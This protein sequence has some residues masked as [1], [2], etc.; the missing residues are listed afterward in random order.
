MKLAGK[1]PLSTRSF[2]TQFV[3][4]FILVL[5]LSLVASIVTYL[6]GIRLYL[7][8]EGRKVQPANYFEQQIPQIEAQIREMGTT[9]LQDHSLLE[10]LV[11]HE[12]LLYQVVDEK[13]VVLY[14]TDRDRR[15]QNRAEL[16]RLINT[17]QGVGGRFFRTI[18]VFSLEAELVGAVSLS[19][20]LTPYFPRLTDK[21]WLFPLGYIIF[22]SPF[23]FIVLFTSLFARKFAENIG[24]PVNLLIDG[25]QTV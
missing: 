14:G 10:R 9:V 20:R 5:V 15:I 21:L 23:L 7:N 1:R 24:E 17:T 19:Y 18:P 16:L 8:V 6:L 3:V 25:A 12:G 4:T 13:G 22:F 2:K 11:P